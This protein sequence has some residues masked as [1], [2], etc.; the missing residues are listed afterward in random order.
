MLPHNQ[1][2]Y[3]GP[4]VFGEFLYCRI[5]IARTRWGNKQLFST[6][7]SVCYIRSN[8]SLI[9][10][11]SLKKGS[12]QAPRQRKQCFPFARLMATHPVKY[13]HNVHCFILIFIF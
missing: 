13:Y 8:A 9:S 11:S 3:L 1:V 4:N 6:M 10:R 2:G 7:D 12:D 5:D